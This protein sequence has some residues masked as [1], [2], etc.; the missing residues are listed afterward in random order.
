MNHPSARK[1]H[2]TVPNCSLARDRSPLNAEVPDCG[3]GPLGR[4]R[5]VVHELVYAWQARRR[6][7]YEAPD[8]EEPS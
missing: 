5:F 4:L 1:D 3:T 7:R 2:T 8:Q 6:R